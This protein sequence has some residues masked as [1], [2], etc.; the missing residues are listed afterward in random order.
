M[1]LGRGR[2][3]VL[4]AS[5]VLAVAGLGAAVG[6]AAPVRGL[7]RAGAAMRPALPALSRIGA[8]DA[9]G[10]R[11]VLIDATGREVVTL[12]PSGTEVAR[13]PTSAD[14]RPPGDVDVA[15]APSGEIAVSRAEYGL[16]ERYSPS[17]VLLEAV[18]DVA[19]ER[20]DAIDY[21]R[22]GVLLVRS[23]SSLGPSTTLARLRPGGRV[24]VV[25]NV[26][27][28]AEMRVLGDRTWLTD[29]TTVTVLR[30]IAPRA[31]IGGDQRGAT[32]D[33]GDFAA[34]GLAD[35]VADG[36][37]AWVSD[38]T[39]LQRFDDHGALRLACGLDWLG[40]APTQLAEIGRTLYVSTTLAIQPV[41]PVP[42]R[43]AG[44]ETP[45]LRLSDVALRTERR[46]GVQQLRLRYR[47]SATARLHVA[48]Y[49]NDPLRCV[50][51]TCPVATLPVKKRARGRGAINYRLPA[52]HLPIGL[53]SVRVYAR[54]RALA[55][56]SDTG[57]L[58]FRVRAPER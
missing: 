28:G 58:P 43:T 3:A 17:G 2:R 6:E 53:Y 54:S 14:P 27:P 29:S 44:C 13:W 50:V 32:V 49:R 26:Q 51:G 34:T 25:S 31:I 48:I 37:G 11:L 41:R 56:R 36:E 52:V 7:V 55:A 46:N 8:L 18:R 24:E 30:G 39:R 47:L 12:D 4:V 45:R 22:D 19:L 10:S 9:D 38:R 21:G 20:P 1:K 16:I 40:G 5:S 57:L 35:V 42:R 33:Q 15:V 23:S